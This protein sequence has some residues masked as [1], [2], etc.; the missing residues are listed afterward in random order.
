VAID[1]LI[2]GFSGCD[3]KCLVRERQARRNRR[4]GR[5]PAQASSLRRGG[6]ME[7]LIPRTPVA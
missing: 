6:P 2:T 1:A 4:T 5:I 7:K 3:T